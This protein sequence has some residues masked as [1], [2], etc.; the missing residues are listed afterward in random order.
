M[1]DTPTPHCPKCDSVE[2][3]PGA[4]C[5][6]C[7]WE[8]SAADAYQHVRAQLGVKRQRIAEL[9]AALQREK[10]WR[11][12]ALRAAKAV[13]R[14]DALLE[15]ADKL[16]DS[17]HGKKMPP[18]WN[19]YWRGEMRDWLRARAEEASDASL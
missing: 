10:G 1:S 19:T 6:H 17:F 13:T 9:E 16:P 18:S 15:A 8:G 2:W 12:Q 5:F 3:F 14:R 7:G 4:A 11:S